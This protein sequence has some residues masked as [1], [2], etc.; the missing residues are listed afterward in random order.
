MLFCAIFAVTKEDQLDQMQDANF[1]Q[2]VWR[3]VLRSGLTLGPMSEKLQAENLNDLLRELAQSLRK[4]TQEVSGVEELNHA[5][6]V[7]RELHERIAILRYRALTMRESETG[8]KTTGNAVQPMDFS[9]HEAADPPQAIDSS[10]DAPEPTPATESTGDSIPSTAKNEGLNPET[11]EI[12]EPE[13]NNLS[14]VDQ[15]QL[16]PLDTLAAG[17]GINDR[18]RFATELF[19]GDMTA[20]NSVCQAIESSDSAEAALT[21]LKNRADSNVD[22]EAETGATAD[23]VALIQRLFIPA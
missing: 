18:V 14:F 16:R 13:S 6:D 20:F 10:D 1:Q 4:L 5:L 19:D 17:M 3:F 15:Q 22:W 12:P 11:V 23:L 7:S 8:P 21:L 2:G 9:I